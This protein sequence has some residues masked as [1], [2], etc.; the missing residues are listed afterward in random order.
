MARCSDLIKIVICEFR[1][2]VPFPQISSEVCGGSVAYEN[3][4][5][6]CKINGETHVVKRLYDAEE[7][8]LIPKGSMVVI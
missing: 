1:R 3:L 8:L 5:S 6:V 2:S 7:Y 4:D